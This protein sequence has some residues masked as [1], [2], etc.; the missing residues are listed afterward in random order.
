MAISKKIK[1]YVPDSTVERKTSKY[2][3]IPKS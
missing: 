1:L 2:Y 3:R